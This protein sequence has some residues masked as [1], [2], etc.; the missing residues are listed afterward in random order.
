M[1][2]CHDGF[3]DA[4]YSALRTPHSACKRGQSTIEYAAVV[5]VTVAALLAMQVYIK[6]GMAGRLRASVDSLGEQNDP[7]HT[8]NPTPMVM[9]Q[10]NDTTTT[11]ILHKDKDVGVYG[12]LTVDVLE[13]TTTINEDRTERTGSETVGPLTQD[14]WQ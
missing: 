4:E 1:R 12:G 13:N 5:A 10:V 7:R 6:R 14:L 9:S 8:S 2:S 3:I 11:S